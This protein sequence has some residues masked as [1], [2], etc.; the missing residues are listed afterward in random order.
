MDVRQ[1]RHESEQS[2]RFL[3]GLVVGSKP[4]GNIY[5]IKATYFQYCY[6]NV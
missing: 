2:L 5:K 1:L 4:G 6:Q 3:C